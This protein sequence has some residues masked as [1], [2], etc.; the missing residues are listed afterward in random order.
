LWHRAPVPPYGWPQSGQLA[1]KTDTSR[2][3]EGHDRRLGF[4]RAVGPREPNR[5]VP[6]RPQAGNRTFPRSRFRAPQL[7]HFLTR[8]ASTDEAS[9]PGGGALSGWEACPAARG[10]ASGP[11][12]SLLGF[13]LPLA[14]SSL[15]AVLLSQKTPAQEL[16]YLPPYARVIR[17][18]LGFGLDLVRA[19]I[20]V[21]GGEHPGKKRVQRGTVCLGLL[22]KPPHGR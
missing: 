3:H 21:P 7:G 17:L 9:G 12:G 22:Q 8:S 14:K 19:G 2:S 16:I 20:T 4:D 10:S 1:A 6:H 5:G 18:R 15:I 11:S 13:P